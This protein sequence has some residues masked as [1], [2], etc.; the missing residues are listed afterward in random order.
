V[1]FLER[2][3]EPFWRRGWF[4]S[5]L[6]LWIEIWAQKGLRRE[7]RSGSFWRVP[8]FMGR[9]L[10]KTFWRP[11]GDL[12]FIYYCLDPPMLH[13]G[14]G[15]FSDLVY[16][17]GRLWGGTHKRVHFGRFWDPNV[18]FSRGQGTVYAAFFTE[19]F[20]NR[21]FSTVFGSFWSISGLFG[22]FGHFWTFWSLLRFLGSGFGLFG[23]FFGVLGLFWYLFIRLLLFGPN[24]V[25]FRCFYDPF[26]DM[27][28]G[29]EAQLPLF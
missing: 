1:I 5:S 15:K 21:V 28:R 24:I 29:C 10:W 27:T 22:H 7:L 2:L 16:F 18:E 19:A 14:F 26:L 12:Y 6:G 25:I 9:S 11:F 3:L 20:W 8:G 23:S 13:L 17:R 4:K